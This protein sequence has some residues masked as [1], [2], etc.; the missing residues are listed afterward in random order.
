M[1]DKESAEA[2][3]TRA[4]KKAVIKRSGYVDRIRSIHALA[5]Q[6]INDPGVVP[7]MLV[8]IEELDDIWAAFKTEDDA[9]L[10]ALIELDLSAE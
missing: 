2:R 6:S 7:Q 1:G 5:Q 3:I 9:V 10:D 8:L 4:K